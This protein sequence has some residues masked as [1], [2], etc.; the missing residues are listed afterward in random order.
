MSSARVQNSTLHQP[1][2]WQER[3]HE[4]RVALLHGRAGGPRCVVIAVAVVGIGGRG[5]WRWRRGDERGGDGGRDGSGGGRAAV[6]Q[7]RRRVERLAAAQ[8][9]VAVWHD[10]RASQASSGG[11]GCGLRHPSGR[12]ACVRDDRVML[13]RFSL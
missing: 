5:C 4:E 7:P 6:V 2:C 12:D 1:K 11:S 9:E 3:V 13:M 8:H 10:L